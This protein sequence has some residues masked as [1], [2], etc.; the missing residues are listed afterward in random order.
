MRNESRQGGFTIM[1]VIISVAIFAL[2]S[3]GIIYLVANLFI[4]SS[5][6]G[7]LL[8]DADQ[9]RHTAFQINSELRNAQTSNTGAYALD[10]AGDQQVI[11]YSNVDG[12]SDIERV[13][14]FIQNGQLI[15]GVVKPTGSPLA[16]NLSSE[17][18]NPVQND[19]ANG[20]A[21][22]FYYYDG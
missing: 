18:T 16:Y 13:R 8:A 5:R 14:Y 6:Q 7:T 9:A 11:F 2:L 20:A 12:G 1:E 4:S 3:W 15:R 19:M 17:T 10:T 22:L 21:P